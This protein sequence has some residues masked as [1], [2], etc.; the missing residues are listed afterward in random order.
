M[1]LD[2]IFIYTIID[3]SLSLLNTLMSYLGIH[4]AS[5]TT[6]DINNSISVSSDLAS[7]KIVTS[8]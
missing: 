3:L 8:L 2:L 5:K 1:I 6:Y 4:D 7:T